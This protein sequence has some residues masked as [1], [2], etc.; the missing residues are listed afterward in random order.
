MRD[1]TGFSAPGPGE[2]KQR[3]FRMEHR[4]ALN[5]VQIFQNAHHVSVLDERRRQPDKFSRMIPY[6]TRR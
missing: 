2:K 4:R 1:D 3:A 6:A 5:V